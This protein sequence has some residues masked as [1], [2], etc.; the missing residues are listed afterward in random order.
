MSTCPG[1]SGNVP[2][3][4]FNSH[5]QAHPDFEKYGQLLIKDLDVDLERY[6]NQPFVSVFFGGGHPVSCHLKHWPRY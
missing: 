6:G 3:C 2:Y 5:E 1:V 4:D